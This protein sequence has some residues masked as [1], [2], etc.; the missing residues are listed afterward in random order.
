MWQFVAN[1]LSARTAKLRD[2]TMESAN[3]ERAFWHMERVRAPDIA[4]I[5]M[6][7]L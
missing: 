6:Q 5:V 2:G 1:C 3:L 7:T 4:S